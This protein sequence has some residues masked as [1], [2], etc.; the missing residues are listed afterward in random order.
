MKLFNL[1]THSHFCDGKEAPEAYVRKAIDL[2]FHTIGFSS[3]APVPFENS[4][5]LPEERVGEYASEIRRLQTEYSDK[6]S[7]CLGLE[8]DF[9]PGITRNFVY[10]RHMAGLDYAIGGVHLVKGTAGEGLWFIDGA[11]A[12][13]YDSGLS[14]VFNGDIRRGV[15]AYYQQI[16]EMV[17][18]QRP[19]IV[20]HLDKIK[21]HNRGRYFSEDEPWYRELVWKTL[22]CIAGSGCIIEVNTRGIYKKRSPAFYPSPA[23]LEQAYHLGI[24]VT[25]SSDAHRPEELDGYLI[26]AI[27]VLRD[28][29]FREMVC[30]D[31]NNRIALPL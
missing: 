31:G 17:S 18:T 28:I 4:F 2:G 12:E 15:E 22:R 13:I 6:I 29:G 25:V 1:H 8:L 26:E 7:V 16:M 20:A 24:P 27:Q 19:D 11:W 9:I 23:I 10:Y 21:M 5:S 14:E 3:H 30:F